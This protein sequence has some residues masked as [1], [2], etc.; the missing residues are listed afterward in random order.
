M[1]FARRSAWSGRSRAPVDRRETCD[2]F[3]T[4]EQIRVRAHQLWEE[5]GGH[6]DAFRHGAERALAEVD[7]GPQEIDQADAHQPAWLSRRSSL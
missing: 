7:D 2:G 3:P 4:D 6:A 1:S 5:A